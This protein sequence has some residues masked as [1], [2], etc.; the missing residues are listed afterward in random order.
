MAFCSPTPRAAEVVRAMKGAGRQVVLATN[1]IFPPAATQARIRWTGLDPQD[2]ALYT[3][4]ENSSWCKPSL[5]YY[6]E[7]LGKLGRAPE[8]CLMVGNDVAEDMVAEELG[9]RVFLLTDCLINREGKDIAAWPHGGF[10]ALMDYWTKLEE[11]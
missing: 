11:G 4:Y 2:C 5:G 3:T 1:P 9:M 10:G 8:E 6:R 7:L